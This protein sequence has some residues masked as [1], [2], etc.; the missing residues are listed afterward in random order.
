[1]DDSILQPD[2]TSLFSSILRIQPHIKLPVAVTV[3]IP[4]PWISE[5]STSGATA[6]LRLV[7]LMPEKEDNMGEYSQWTWKDVTSVCTL[8][9][10]G[11]CCQFQTSFLTT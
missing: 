9:L 4:C 2:E 8:T 6:N 1:M 3:T 10:V 5:N 7:A 11:S